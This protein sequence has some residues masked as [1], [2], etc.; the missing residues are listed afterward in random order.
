V[1]ERMI[2]AMR[3]LLALSALL[4]IYIDPSE[5]DRFVTVTY[6]TLALYSL[7]SA[8][9]YYGASTGRPV[10][11]S[12]EAHWVDVCWY[13]VLIALSSGTN[14][15]FF[16]FF[17]FAILTAAFR[18]GFVEGLRVTATSVFVFTVV[19][20]ATTPHDVEIELN[21]YLLR[22][23]YLGVLGYMIS[24]W[25][26]AEIT[27]KRRLA[28]LKEVNTLSN[29]RFGVDQT[30]GSILERV[31]EFYGADE[32]LLV[33]AEGDPPAY[34]L[35]RADRRHPERAVHAQPVPDE[36]RS[37]LLA[38]PPDYA[39][40]FNRD[41]EWWRRDAG[42]YALDTA[43]GVRSH[44]AAE[45][46]EALSD[47]LETKAFV[48]VPVR[49]RGEV[50]GRLYMTSSKR[51]FER[52]D[53]EFL[54]QLLE[55]I[56]PVIEN[57]QLLDTLATEAADQERRRLSLDIH[58]S[59]VQPY[60]GLRMGLEALRRKARPDNPLREDI[61]TLFEQA[62][63]S[64]ADLRGFV[65]GMKDEGT[66]TRGDVLIPA[67]RR[68]AHKFGELYGIKVEVNAESDIFVSDRLAAEVFQIV[69]EGLTNV[70]RHTHSARAFVSVSRSGK[71]LVVS[72]ENERPGDEPDGHFTPRSI[73]ERAAAAGGRARVEQE[74]GRTAVTVEIPL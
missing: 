45:S 43:Q 11:P 20:F 71:Q 28:L 65:R 16:F 3:L 8:I 39:F 73:T 41:P 68:Q 1:D 74:G 34:L 10:L 64:L 21:R 5:P 6:A 23:L 51:S 22:S 14:S 53:V 66:G 9:L 44:G 27:F 25:G 63:A 56:A 29:P 57:V 48:A 55:H 24:F 72:V 33:T 31:R 7:Y 52:G 42:C 40:V 47:L 26:G 58:D 32:C 46:C 17:F 61:D 2:G 19:G 69:R 59:A 60:I 30:V 36:M 67:L 13:V 15:V 70:R 37:S 4:V 12:G 35:R 50:V 54:R 62:S 18:K 38:L 49:R